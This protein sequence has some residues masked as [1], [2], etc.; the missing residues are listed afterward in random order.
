[1]R[2]ICFYGNHRLPPKYQVEIVG[3]TDER[4]TE[5]KGHTVGALPSRESPFMATLVENHRLTSSGH[6]QD[7]RLITF[8]IEGSG[9]RYGCCIVS[10]CECVCV[11]YV[12]TVLVMW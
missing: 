3:D 2:V 6:F 11:V 12:A 8:N 4:C 10:C 7:V 5:V 9:I 1:M